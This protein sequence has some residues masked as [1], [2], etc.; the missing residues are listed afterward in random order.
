MSL[1]R[2][3]ACK[4]FVGGLSL[5]VT[6]TEFKDHFGKYG[7]VKEGIIMYDRNSGLSRG[8]GF[9]TFEKEDSVE[10]VL[11]TEHE[12]KGKVVE[13]KRAEPREPRSVFLS[14]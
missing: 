4:I 9:I 1:C 14:W 13:I 6:E 12:L 2:S 11:K 10:A 8:F 5:E 7:V 3:E